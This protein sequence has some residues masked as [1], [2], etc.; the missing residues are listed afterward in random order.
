MTPAP[1]E[2]PRILYGRRRGRRLRRAQQVL[3]DEL[4]PALEIAPPPEIGRAHV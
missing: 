4:L 2:R 1:E 3:L